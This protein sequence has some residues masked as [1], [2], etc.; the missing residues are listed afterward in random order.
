MAVPVA[1]P[2]GRAFAVG[3]RAH[4]GNVP[5]GHPVYDFK[6]S[7]RVAFVAAYQGPPLD[8]PLR[9]DCVF[10]MPRPK[11][12]FWKTRPMPRLPYV[13]SKNDWDNL[14]KTVSDA[15]LK[16]A[17][18]DDGQLCVVRIERWIAAGD[19]VPHVEICIEQSVAA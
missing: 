1:Q 19:E 15:L 13:A 18:R 3:G 17:Y 7:L 2:R 9:M 16:V 10:V 12:L 11:G 8:G 4:M 6:A 14:G 5:S